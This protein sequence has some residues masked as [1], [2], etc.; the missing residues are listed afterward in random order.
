VPKAAVDP[1]ALLAHCRER[2]ASYKVPRHLWLRGED[3]LPQKGS[4]KADK[5]ALRT[6][7]ARLAADATADGARPGDRPA[8]KS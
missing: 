4:G 8:A 6:E 5:T 7:A 1:A 2:L 3:A